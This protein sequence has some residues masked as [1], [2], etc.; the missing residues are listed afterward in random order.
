[1]GSVAT[2]AL[3]NLSVAPTQQTL[4]ATPISEAERSFI[5]F[6][7]KYHRTYGTKEEYQH[8]LDIFTKNYHNMMSHNMMNSETEGYTMGINKFADMSDQEYKMLLGYKSNS[9]S[10]RVETHLDASDL[11]ASVDWRQK[12]AVTP[13]SRTKDSVDHAGPSQPLD[14]LREPTLSQ[15]ETLF[16]SLSNNL[17]TVQP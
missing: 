17:L 6:V 2:F 7:A 13:V 9:S 8:R 16:L 10:N 4:L 11:P 5:D 12:N 15:L 3:F 1:V 14:P